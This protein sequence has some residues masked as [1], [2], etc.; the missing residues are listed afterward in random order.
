MTYRYDKD[1]L[2]LFIKWE[3]SLKDFYDVAEIVLIRVFIKSDISAERL[4]NLFI[5]IV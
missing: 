5:N 1:I 3:N 4:Q 2:S